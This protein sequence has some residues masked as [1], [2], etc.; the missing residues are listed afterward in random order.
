MPKLMAKLIVRPATREDIDA[1]SDMTDKPTIRAYVAEMDGKV[2]AIAGAARA[3]GRWYAFADLPDEIRPYKM[4]IMRN[5]KRFIDDLRRQGVMFLYAQPDPNEPKAIAWLSSLGFE[6][7][8]RSGGIL[9]R[10]SAK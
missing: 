3:K 2:I 4:T 8:P 5:A 10:W 9:Y 6:P 1:F 7:D